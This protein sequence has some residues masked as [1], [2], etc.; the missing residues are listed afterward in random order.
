MT[1][2]IKYLCLNSNPYNL[3]YNLPNG[4]EEL[5]LRCFFNSAM[6]NLPTSIKTIQLNSYAYAHELNCMQISVE[7]LKLNKFY[8]KKFQIFKKD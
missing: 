5:E 1:N 8:K 7:C 2:E 4:I 6:N 3:I